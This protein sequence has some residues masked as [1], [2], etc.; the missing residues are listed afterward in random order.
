MSKLIEKIKILLVEDTPSD[1]ELITRLLK[2]EGC[3][4]ALCSDGKAALDYLVQKAEKGEELPTVILLDLKLP[5][6]SGVELLRHMHASLKL[7][8]I[9]VIVLTSSGELKDIEA[10]FRLGVNRYV[11][12]PIDF[13]S[14]KSEMAD[15]SR[16]LRQIQE[17]RSKLREE[18]NRVLGET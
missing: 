3:Q 8:E 4:V 5:K 2:K 10:C 18:S 17:E 11:Q 6:I 15:I 9:P 1:A 16:S 14:F 13:D 12:K 7:R